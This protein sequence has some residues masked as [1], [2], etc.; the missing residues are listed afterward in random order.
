MDAVILVI[1]RHYFRVI[2][3]TEEIKNQAKEWHFLAFVLFFKKLLVFLFSR[4]EIYMWITDLKISDKTS[5][6]HF[7]IYGVI[8]TL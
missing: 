1:F 7:K 3:K 5:K 6:R 8:V 2:L 4:A